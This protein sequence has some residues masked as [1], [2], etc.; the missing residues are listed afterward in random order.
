MSS[1]I[2]VN[3]VGTQLVVTVLDDGAV[4][5]IS[6]ATEIYI[7]L[8]KPDGVTYTKTASLYSDGTDGKMEYTTE[9]DDLNAAGN[10]K[11]QGK[12]VLG[13]GTYFTSLGTFKVHCNL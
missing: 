4:V 5:D 11:I 6:T 2:H 1:E 8:R 9:A 10:Y 12:V 7:L 3:D 13:G